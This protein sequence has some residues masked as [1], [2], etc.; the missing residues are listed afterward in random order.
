M[1]ATGTA[2]PRTGRKAM[3]AALLLVALVLGIAACRG[4]FGQAPIALLVV[5]PVADEEVPVE[6]TFNIA[7]STDPDGTIVGYELDFGDAS[8]AATGTDVT[9]VIVHEY[10]VAGVYVVT[11][12]VT[13]DDGRIGM[14]QATVTVGAAMIT[15][16]VERDGDYDIWRMLADGSAQ[17]AV[18]N[19]A[20]EEIF[21]DLIRGTRNRIAYAG[22]AMGDWNIY[23]MGTDGSSIALLTSVTTNE[24]QPSW[25]SDASLIAYAS[26]AA[27]TPSTTT[28]EIWTM[29]A[30]GGAQ[31]QL[32][33]QS[34]S[35]AIAPAYSPVNDDVVFVSDMDASGGSSIWL[36]D[37]SAG[38]AIEI[39][40][41]AAVRDGDASPAGFDAGLA[42]ALG[43]PPDAGVSRPAWSPDG[44]KIAF[45]RERIAG[46]I[47]D[48]WIMNADGSG[49]LVLEEYIE[50]LL[51]TTFADTITTAADEF[52]PY[53]LEDGS[54]IAFTRVDGF[55]YN[56]VFVSFADGSVTALTGTGDNV[57]PAEERE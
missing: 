33:T 40:D 39:Y 47:I 16:A 45:S 24:I 42:T 19:T 52:A 48:L 1:P 23:A 8:T 36:W 17:G 13:D 34:P 15:F 26:N 55:F 6:F 54:G 35:W 57:F 25:S 53:W 30:A 9:D 32:T 44:S 43:L 50:A 14:A 7:G 21:P 12:T 2:A 31:T 37:D 10:D 3:L 4:F 46:G 29:T 18:L 20:T 56:I 28:W 38:F 22:D 41:G 49:A 11:L 51:A 27:Q 5:P